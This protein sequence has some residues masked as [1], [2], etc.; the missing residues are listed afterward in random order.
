MPNETFYSF[1]QHDDKNKKSDNR[2]GEKPLYC[3]NYK[4]CELPVRIITF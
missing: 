1:Y 4:I 2:R 3:I